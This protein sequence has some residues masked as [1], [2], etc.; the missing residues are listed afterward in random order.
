MQ[1]KLTDN[2]LTL[3]PHAQVSVNKY[4]CSLLLM[5]YSVIY[6]TCGHREFKSVIK[7]R[8]SPAK[9]TDCIHIIQRRFC[10]ASST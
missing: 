7:D 3:L 5:M 10:S 8:Q 1:E 4:V 9:C 2:Y 6:G